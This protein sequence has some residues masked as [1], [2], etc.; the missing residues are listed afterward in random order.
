MHMPKELTHW[1]IADRALARLGHNSR[2][3][4]IILSHRAVYLGG[5]VLPDTL[6]HLF[7]G[8]HA[9]TALALAHSFHNTSGNSFE[10]LIQAEQ[11]YPDGLPPALLSCL[12]GVITHI[13]V[14]IAF[15][16]FVFARAGTAGIGQHYRIETDIDVCFLRAGATPPLQRVSKLLS[17]DTRETLVSACVLLFDPDTTL[18]RPALEKALALHGRFQALYDR[19][20]WKLAVRVL[21]ISK[22]S[23]LRNLRHLF[24]PLTDA[25]ACCIGADIVQWR[26]PVSGEIRNTTLE[27]L[28][29]DAVRRIA[30]LFEQIEAAGSLA[31]VLRS[32]PGE[33]LLTGMHTACQ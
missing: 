12:L 10:P 20:F 22:A 11:R 33:N 1:L 18:P 3:R 32:Q 25:S 24:Y 23:P 6:L 31:T 19:T 15:H 8:S 27:Q 4:E 2:L 30:A 28:A 14:D 21:T 13:A 7:R 17:P 26:H 16:P 5:A 29:D 9:S